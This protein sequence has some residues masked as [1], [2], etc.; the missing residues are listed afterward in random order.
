MEHKNTTINVYFIDLEKINVFDKINFSFCKKTINITK[1]LITFD[2]EDEKLPLE[3]KYYFYEKISLLNKIKES[4]S[5]SVSIYKNEI[6]NLI[7]FANEHSNYSFEI[8]YYDKSLKNLPNKII[9]NNYTISNYDNFGLQSCRRFNIIN[10]PKDFLKTV[11]NNN[12]IINPQYNKGS[13]LVTIEKDDNFNNIRVF[14]I[15]REY[16]NKQLLSDLSIDDISPKLLDVEKFFE[17]IMSDKANKINKKKQLDL[18]NKFKNQGFNNVFLDY[19]KFTEEEIKKM[20]YYFY[21]MRRIISEKIKGKEIYKEKHLEYCF[22]YHLF[23]FFKSVTN[24]SDKTHL[25]ILFLDFYSNLQYNERLNIEQKINVLYFYF[26]IKRY[27][28]LDSNDSFIKIKNIFENEYD[29]DINITYNINTIDNTNINK[30]YTDYEN[31]TLKIEQSLTASEKNQIAELKNKNKQ[32]IMPR[33]KNIKYDEPIITFIDDCKDRSPYK[34]SLE[35]LKKIILNIKEDSKLFELLFFV[36]SGTGNNKMQHEITYKLSLLSEK[37]IKD[38]LLSVIP[39]FILRESQETNYNAFFSPKSRL[40]MINENSMFNFSLEEGDNLLV[41]KEDL[42]GKYTIPLLMLFMHELFGHANHMY[43]IKTKIG[44][45]RSPTNISNKE[46]SKIFNYSIES[47]GESRRAV[48]FY[49][50]KFLEVI[51]YLKFSGDEFPELLNYEEWIK[52]DFSELNKMI[53]KKIL[54]SN[55][56]SEKS[57]LIFPT[58]VLLDDA[59]LISDSDE[60]YN[61]HGKEYILYKADFTKK[62]KEGKSFGCI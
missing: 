13:F 1:R 42:N 33:E 3:C 8:I 39:T 46:D 36:T 47:R 16:Y 20:D 45:E 44:K 22:N 9:L 18:Q 15:R 61:F 54:L 7:C 10:C 52:P 11:E 14:K 41:L 58:P 50:S 2:I 21:T 5:F 31:L 29:K 35:L 34:Q 62:M 26:E 49:I 27:N 43:R 55:F 25:Y 6:N 37:K 19:M 40:L 56:K 32:R 59:S 23:N 28:I 30:D 48:E 53:I 57:L 51:L 38:I 24:K 12:I 17:S 60:E 4:Y